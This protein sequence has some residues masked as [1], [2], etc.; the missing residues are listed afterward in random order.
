REASRLQPLLQRRLVI[1]SENVGLLRLLDR[2]L[3]LAAKKRGRGLES[4]VEIHRGD[5]RL[6][7]IRQQRL[8]E[9][10]AALLLAAPEEQVLA[11]IEPLR[12][13]GERLRGDDRR[14][15]LG[16]LSFAVR[17]VLPEQHV[18]DDEPE[19]GIAQELERLVV[20]DAPRHILRRARAVRQRVLEEAAILE[21]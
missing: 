20:D 4:A 17:R 8:L 6:V 19:H 2:R 16:L 15:D 1:A 3:E 7:G 18:G 14:L 21:A 12:V 9:A 13:P 10:P 5:E 11:E